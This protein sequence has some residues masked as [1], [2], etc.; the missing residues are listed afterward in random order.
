MRLP[1]NWVIERSSQYLIH[2]VRFTN[3]QPRNNIEN[4]NKKQKI[5]KKKNQKYIYADINN[6]SN[7]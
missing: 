7:I 4:E 1:R 5:I 3:N 6:Q 2:L